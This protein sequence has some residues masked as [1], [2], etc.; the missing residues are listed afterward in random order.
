MQ[1]LSVDVDLW[2]LLYQLI[3]YFPWYVGLVLIPMGIRVIIER[4]IGIRQEMFEEKAF[5][6]ISPLLPVDLSYEDAFRTITLT[7]LYFPL[8]EELVFRGLPYIFFGTL[9]VM[10]GSAVWV[11]MHPAWQLQHISSLPLRKKLVFTVTSTFYYSANAVFYSMMWLNGA[12]LAAILYHA[13]HNGWLTFADIIKE[14]ELP[15]P[16]KRYKYVRK[17]PI[18][19]ETPRILRLF[20]RRR[21]GPRKEGGEEE[22]EELTE[23]RFVVKKPTR[24][25]NDLADEAKE[26]MF[27][28]KKIKN[29]EEE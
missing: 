23:M 6:K 17:Q 9:G 2:A 25:L 24:S 26:F 22:L 20:R 3:Y 11:L 10:I 13:I 19:D 12:G 8:L 21:P 1:Q 5:P 16:W 27:V 4:S 28:R 15:A 14:I 7:V 18:A 29:E